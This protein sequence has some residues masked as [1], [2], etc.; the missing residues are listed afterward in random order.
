LTRLQL[1]EADK[2]IIARVLYNYIYDMLVDT[3]YGLCCN[4]R[5]AK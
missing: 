2:I 4:G 1:Y 5:A 3:L